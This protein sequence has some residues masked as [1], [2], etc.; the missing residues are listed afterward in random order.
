MGSRLDSCP[1][2]SW[3][4]HKHL[5]RAHPSFL[6][7]PDVL[8]PSQQLTFNHFIDRCNTDAQR[9]AVTTAAGRAITFLLLN[10]KTRLIYC[11]VSR[12]CVLSFIFISSLLNEI[13]ISAKPNETFSTIWQA[14]FLRAVWI[15]KHFRVQARFFCCSYTNTHTHTRRHTRLL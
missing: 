11:R 10:G 6:I 4:E 9:C 7:S 5:G 8:A 2:Q 14:R 13:Q 1:G 15:L 3:L 12:Q